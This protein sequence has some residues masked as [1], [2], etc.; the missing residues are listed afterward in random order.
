MKKSRA[1]SKQKIIIILKNQCESCHS[2][3]MHTQCNT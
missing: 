2:K 1:Q 3:Y